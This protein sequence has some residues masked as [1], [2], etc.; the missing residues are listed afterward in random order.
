MRSEALLTLPHSGHGGSAPSLFI[1]VGSV[2]GFWLE[3][4]LHL[5][6]KKNKYNS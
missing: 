6:I 2:S 5:F 3:F 1:M 4:V